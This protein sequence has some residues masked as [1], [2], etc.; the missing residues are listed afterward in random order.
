[1]PAITG[2]VLSR[3]GRFDFDVVGVCERGGMNPAD[4]RDQ[5]HI[6]SCATSITALLFA[7]LV[8]AGKTSW[9]Q[10]VAD[11]FPDIVTEIDSGWRERSVEDLF[12]CVS[13]MRANPT[14]AELRAGYADNRP[15]PEQR[16]DAVISAMRTSPGPHGRFAYSNLSYMAIGAAIDR[17]ADMPYEEALEALL[18]SEVRVIGAGRTDT[19]VHARGQVAHIAG[20]PDPEASGQKGACYRRADEPGRPGDQIRMR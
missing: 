12:L 6:G 7:R 16:T 14:I 1:M 9:D 3:D 20:G 15:L 17:I 18:N 8:E 13:G 2:G 11:C 4:R 5:W 19:G 10:P